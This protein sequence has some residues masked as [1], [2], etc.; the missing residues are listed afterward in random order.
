MKNCHCEEGQGPDE[1]THVF[2]AAEKQKNGLLQVLRA[3][4]VTGIVA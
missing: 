1:A 2:S 4:A 3:F